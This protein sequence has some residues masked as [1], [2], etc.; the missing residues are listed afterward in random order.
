M[1]QIRDLNVYF[2][3]Q[4]MD[5]ANVNELTDY[6]PE[7]DF[8]KAKAAFSSECSINYL[9]FN[10]NH[11]YFQIG[12]KYFR[13][14]RQHRDVVYFSELNGIDLGT[15]SS[16]WD[17]AYDN[18]KYGFNFQYVTMSI[19]PTYS[20]SINESSNVTVGI[21]GM[22]Y[23]AATMQRGVEVKTNPNTFAITATQYKGN[24]TDF[25]L[26]YNLSS[27]FYKSLNEKIGL[28]F[29]VEYNFLKTSIGEEKESVLYYG[30]AD[31]I[32]EN[33]ISVPIHKQN[34]DL[35]GLN[36]MVGASF[37]INNSEE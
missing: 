11:F 1:S 34:L 8:K 32:D 7:W 14:K 20:F 30:N 24:Y 6:G 21:G 22:F 9:P 5:V 37:R 33:G 18:Y 13:L 28:T 29:K 4:L 35:S 10:T 31:Y 36:V 23:W 2:G 12:L 16:G 25:G 27:A 15:P 19:A 3:S 26:T 17:L